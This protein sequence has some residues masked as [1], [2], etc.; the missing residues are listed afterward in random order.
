MHPCVAMSPKVFGFLCTCESLQH[1]Q[2]K[3][4]YQC[5][6]IAMR[7]CWDETQYAQ[8]MCAFIF[9]CVCAGMEGQAR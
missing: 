2:R 1:G 5:N 9:V 8:C 7:S 6:N 4:Q 3:T